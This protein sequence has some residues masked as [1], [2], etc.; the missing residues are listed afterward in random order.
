MNRLL[1]LLKS[2][3][4]DIVPIGAALVMYV[5]LLNKFNLVVGTGSHV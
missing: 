4:D 1:N 5:Y 2:N 3:R